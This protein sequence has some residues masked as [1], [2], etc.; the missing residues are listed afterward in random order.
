[1]CALRRDDC[2]SVLFRT[3]GETIVAAYVV[4]KEPAVLRDAT[5]SLAVAEF[6]RNNDSEVCDKK[7]EK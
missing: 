7:K 6:P 5:G 4:S 2:T 1:M 3:T